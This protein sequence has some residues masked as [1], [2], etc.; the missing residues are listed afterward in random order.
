MEKNEYFRSVN[1]VNRM[2]N[3]LSGNHFPLSDKGSDSNLVSRVWV[4]VARFIRI[5]YLITTLSGTFYF[6]D[7]TAGEAFK[8]LGAVAALFFESSTIAIYLHFCG[9]DLGD[10]A[11]KCND[12]FAG[13]DELKKVVRETIAPYKK[14]VRFNMIVCIMTASVWSAGSYL[15]V[16]F[17]HEFTYAD[18]AVPAYFPGEPFTVNVFLAGV[19]LQVLGLSLTAFA[20]NSTDAY[21]T[22]FIAVLSAE[23]KYVRREMSNALRQE[24]DDETAVVEALQICVR[25][26]CATIEIA[27]KLCDLMAIHIGITYFSCIVKFC[28]LGFSI[29][30]FESAP[31]EKITFVVYT[32]SCVLQV[33]LVCSCIQELLDVSTSV[34]QDAFHENWHGRS[35]AVKNI[36]YTIEM[37]NTMEC[38]LSCYRVVDLVVP[39]LAQILSKAYSAC[40]LFLEVN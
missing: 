19:T 29:I 8:R 6:A 11:R 23:Y 37:S 24:D 20:K 18:F 2:A 34:T 39:S 17:K 16:F 21:V 3:I 26:H 1:G 28:F 36:F 9:K 25:H 12:T 27:Q 7:I 5:T 4:L 15:L 33:F 30:R 10:L 32:G 40:L 35:T 38:R 14:G 31:I 13:S 22:H